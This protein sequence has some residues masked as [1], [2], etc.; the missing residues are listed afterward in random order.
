MASEFSIDRRLIPPGSRVLCA[1][2]GGADSVCMLHALLSLGDV[3]CVCA[4]FDHGLRPD[5]AGDA[6]F[7]AGLCESWGVELIT[8]RGDTGKYAAENRLS[9]ETAAR[10]LRYAFLRRA[11][12]ACGAE[13]IATAHNRNDN[14]ETVLLHLARGAGLRGLT[15]IPERRD[16]VVRPLLRVSRE[17]ILSYLDE[18]GIPHVEDPT[19]AL[20]DCARNYARHHVLPA[21][22]RLHPG[23]LGN[24]SRMTASLSEDE[25]YLSSL[26]EDWLSRQENGELSA[27]ELAALPRPVAARA[28]RLWLG[29][30]LSRERIGALLDLCSAGPSAMLD[31]PGRRVY[32]RYDALTLTAPRGGRLPDRELLPERELLLPEAGLAVLC[33]E[34]PPAGEIQSSFNTFYFSSANICGK[35]TVACR[36]PGDSLT[37]LG[38]QGRRS[39]KKLLMER[40]IPREKRESVPVLRDEAGVLAVY[41]VGQSRRAFPRPGEPYCAVT[42]RELTEEEK[43]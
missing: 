20:D 12:A 17:E 41:G 9:T 40:R 1:V 10:E 5:S 22:E 3:T 33:R 24:I 39:V 37:L 7:V 43:A 18:R 35:L 25:A 26:A 23:A 19:N 32:R 16:N 36:K 6:A 27:R 8:E 31:L 29:E 2:S 14:A 11:A 34:C 15:G 4:H 42:F 21:M 13:L 28:L 38:R 30:D